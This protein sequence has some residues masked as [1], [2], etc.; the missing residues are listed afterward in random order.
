MSSVKAYT[1]DVLKAAQNEAADML[2]AFAETMANAAKSNADTPRDVPY[3]VNTI[4]YELKGLAVKVFT[5]CGYGGWVHE[6]TSKMEGRP[7][8]KWAFDMAVSS[9]KG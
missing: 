2:G 7:F 1:N 4:G 8:F 6:G 3:M 9:F 5:A